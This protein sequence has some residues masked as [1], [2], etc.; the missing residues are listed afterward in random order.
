[1]PR[2]LNLSFFKRK[3][4]LSFYLSRFHLLLYS[5]FG[6]SQAH[7]GK[8]QF[9]RPTL[10]PPA[11]KPELLPAKSRAVRNPRRLS[12]TPS[13]REPTS[14]PAPPSSGNPRK[15][16]RTS[17]VREPPEPQPAKTSDRES[18]ETQPAKD[19]AGEQ[20]RAF[21]RPAI[22]FR[23]RAKKSDEKTKKAEKGL[24]FAA[25]V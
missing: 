17:V 13:V 14:P 7:P 6:Q 4:F 5:V 3:P 19:R 24:D 22:L 2:I 23:C 16:S 25:G 10:K 18:T 11:G 1:M 12:H 8:K 15:F 20:T 21:P 9:A